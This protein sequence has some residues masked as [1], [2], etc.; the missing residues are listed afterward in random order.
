M[1]T[2]FTSTS[3]LGISQSRPLRRLSQKSPPQCH[4]LC[5]SSMRSD[6]STG[7]IDALLCPTVYM[8]MRTF[9]R[10]RLAIAN[11]IPAVDPVTRTIFP[12]S[13]RSTSFSCGKAAPSCRHVVGSASAPALC[14]LP[15]PI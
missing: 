15:F 3:T 12:V 7:S 10:K 13:L 6:C 11:P 1:P 8:D 2:L 14:P 9:A 5:R 4:Q